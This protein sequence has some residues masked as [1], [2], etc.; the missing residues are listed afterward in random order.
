MA[1][2]GESD[3]AVQR[4]ESDHPERSEEKDV[5]RTKKTVALFVAFDGEG[6]QGW[7]Y[8]KDLKTL[9][10]VLEEAVFKSGGIAEGNHKALSKV[11]WCRA[12]RTDKG[13]SAAGQVVSFRMMY[14]SGDI[15]S[16]INAHLP[17]E[18]RVLGCVRTTR[19]FNAWKL[20]D[21]RQY[22]YCLPLWALDK[23]LKGPPNSADKKLSKEEAEGKDGEENKPVGLKFD[24]ALKTRMNSLMAAYLGTHD[25]HNFTVKIIGGSSQ[26]KRHILRF[27][28]E[29]SVD[30]H[31]EEWVRV[32][33]LGQSFMLHQIRKMIGFIIA[34]MRDLVEPDS[35]ATAL[36]KDWNVNVPVAPSVGL[37]LDETFYD[38]YNA[39]WGKQQEVVSLEPF[40]SQAE[41][42]KRDR[43]YP[44]I[45]RRNRENQEFVKWIAELHDHTPLH[46]QKWGLKDYQR[47]KR[48]R[49]IPK[50]GEDEVSEGE[51]KK[52]KSSELADA[53][54]L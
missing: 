17:E 46:F 10:G 54:K 27:A 44:S 37:F 4:T 47:T 26:A 41:S 18:I 16:E 3:K 1:A 19:Q 22:E 34:V 31:G 29:D 52:A 43:I 12:A 53:E 32:R 36:Q 7:Q 42:F 2:E 39:K 38:A 21:K 11:N 6:Y 49:E 33:V 50:D 24:D 51:N 48:Q 40:R 15:V 5:Q 13:V 9:E 23:N 25:F 45:A 35:L 20:C 14:H 8:L 28:A 30:F